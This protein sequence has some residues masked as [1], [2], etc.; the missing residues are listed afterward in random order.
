MPLIGNFIVIVL[1]N[2]TSINLLYT[3]VLISIALIIIII[4]IIDGKILIL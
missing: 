4:V 2:I 1:L 3:M